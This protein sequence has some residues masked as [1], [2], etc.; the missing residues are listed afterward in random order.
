MSYS[1][2]GV[3]SSYHIRT[4]MSLRRRIILDLIVHN[5]H[6]EEVFFSLLYTTRKAIDLFKVK[7]ALRFRELVTNVLLSSNLC[8]HP[9]M[10]KSPGEITP[11]YILNTRAFGSHLLGGL[12]TLQF[13]L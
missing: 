12:F 11:S 9:L 5:I 8:S 10:S 3:D 6:K 7:V 1:V 13:F 4:N 2:L